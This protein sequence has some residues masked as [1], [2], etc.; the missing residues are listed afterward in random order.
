MEP[1]PLWEYPCYPLSTVQEIFT[2]DFENFSSIKSPIT[3]EIKLPLI[4]EGLLN[5]VALWYEIE[6]DDNELINGGLLEKPVLNKKLVWTKNYKQ[7]VHILDKKYEINKLN[8]NNMDLKCVFNFDVKLGKIDF[9]FKSNE[10][11]IIEG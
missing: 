1:H 8:M 2:V 5:G 6:F 7:A 10:S 9:D 11:S 3:K 4:N